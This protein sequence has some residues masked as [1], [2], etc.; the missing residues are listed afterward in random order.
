[1]LGIAVMLAACGG[2]Q[3]AAEIGTNRLK[4]EWRVAAGEG[5]TAVVTLV[6]DGTPHELGTLTTTADDKPA[7]PAY[8]KI[9]KSDAVATELECGNTPAYNYFAAELKSGQLVVTHV[10]GV[11]DDPNSEE[12]KVVLRQD[13]AQTSF[14][15]LPFVPPAPSAAVPATPATPAT[16]P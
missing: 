4:V 6:V 12:R 5:E 14:T 10:A 8:C 3:S 13:A 2:P 9:R 7:S 16:G 11:E 15:I 1:M